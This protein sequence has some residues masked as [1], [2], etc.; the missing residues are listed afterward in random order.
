LKIIT[1]AEKY[2]GPV[3]N[4][5]IQNRGMEENVGIGKEYRCKTEDWKNTRIL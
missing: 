2:S 3:S 4:E 1:F 5:A